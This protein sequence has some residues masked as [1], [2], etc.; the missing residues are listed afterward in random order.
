MEV[1]GFTKI[2]SGHPALA[3]VSFDVR[4]GEILGLI[5][6]NGA[7][8]TTLLEAVVGLLPVD[9]GEVAWRGL[10][11]AVEARR[12]FIFY[13]PDGLRPWDEQYVSR[14]LEF[15]AAVYGRSEQ[16]VSDIVRAAGLTT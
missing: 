12:D 10:P 11:I 16:H 9:A 7:G 8:K 5:G 13:L 15:F 4:P 3:Q 6:P 14:V 1:F 2:Y